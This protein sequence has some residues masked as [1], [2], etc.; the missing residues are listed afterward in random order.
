MA[1]AQWHTK[2]SWRRTSPNRERE[3]A[4]NWRLDEEVSL[5]LVGEIGLHQLDKAF[6]V[7]DALPVSVAGFGQIMLWDDGRTVPDTVQAIFEFPD[8]V[9]MMYD[10][11]LTSSFDGEYDLFFGSDSTIM[12][13]DGT[14]AWMFKEVD[15][16]MLGWEVYAR[17][18]QFYKEQGIAL[19]ANATQLDAQAQDPTE[20]DPNAETP[21]FHALKAFLDNYAFG[22]YPPAADY[23]RGYEAAVVAIKA[24]EAIM[25]NTKVTYDE[26]WFDIG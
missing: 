26:S 22:P 13:R 3:R 9:H 23:Q 1:R 12:F 20:D 6:W 4:L 5:G 24:H 25:G 2:Q 14:K 18:D 21:L 7:L 19:L 10:A 15:A 8:G 16:P 17:K 11:T